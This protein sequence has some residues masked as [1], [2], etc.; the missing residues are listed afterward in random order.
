MKDNKSEKQTLPPQ[1]QNRQPGIESEMS[2][3]PQ[4]E[5]SD[6]FSAKRLKNKIAVVTGGDSG[7]GR[8]TAI[9]FAKEGADV[10]IVYKDEHSDAE[11]TKQRIEELGRKCLAL[12]GDIGDEKTCT[13]IVEE[14]RRR[15]DHIDILVNNAAEQHP[16][17]SIEEISSEQ[18]ERTFKTNI[19][20]YFY[21]TKAC[22]K[23]MPKGSA[24]INSTSVTAFRG[25]DHLLDYASTKGAIV[26]FTRSL[27]KALT[28]R[29]IRVNAVAPGPVWTPLIPASFEKE[30]VKNFGS[31]VPM[32]RPAQPAEIAP[33]YVFL[34]SDDA[35]YMTGQTLHPNGGEAVG[36]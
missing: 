3:E 7:I 15:F 5:R 31:Q 16:K 21:M 18:L 25:S 20:S 30:H 27:A 35:S 34:A 28:E 2:P 29:N 32:Q 36:G 9:S 13:Q 17:Q 6:D 12:A 23:Y 24:V 14:I 19:Y 33:C 22:L 1:H 10:V 8:A 11:K 26:A 4:Y